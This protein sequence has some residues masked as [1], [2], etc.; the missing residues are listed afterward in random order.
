MRHTHVPVALRAS[1]MRCMEPQR[2][3]TSKFYTN[4]CP[5]NRKEKD[6]EDIRVIKYGFSCAR[7]FICFISKS[8]GAQ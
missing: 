2:I 1:E 6:H 5:E 8:H 3:C 4:T 7:H